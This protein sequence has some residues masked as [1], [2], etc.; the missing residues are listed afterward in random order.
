MPLLHPSLS[1]L[2]AD[3]AICVGGGNDPLIEYDAAVA[4]CKA[5]GKT[6]ANFVCND[7]LSCFPHVVQHAVT[8]HPDKWQYWRTLRERSGLPAVIRKWSH[9][10]YLDFTDHTK[11]WQGSSGLLCVKIARE[12]G[13]TH[14]ILVGIPMTIEGEHFARGQRWNAAP[15]FRKGWARVQ[16]A[17]RPFV[18]SMSGWTMEHFGLPD[19]EW[20]A[21]TIPDQF[22][23]TG[24]HDHSGVKA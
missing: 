12:L 9:R 3:V 13:Y 14:I 5:S 21:A 11:D 20:L 4:L 10:P 19:A 15:G 16:G 23:M 1:A 8:L 2:Q 17:L 7:M 24:L 22:P 18:R 6:Y